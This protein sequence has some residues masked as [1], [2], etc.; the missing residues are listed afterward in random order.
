VPNEGR[1]GQ[2]VATRRLA[3]SHDLFTQEALAFIE[4]H[5]NRPFF[6]YLAYTIPH[7]NNEAGSHGMEVPDLGAY[8]RTDWPEQ[9]KAFAAMVTRLDR[10]VGRLRAKL[11]E[12]DLDR[13]TVLFFSSDNGP[14]REGGHDPNFFQ[15]SGGLRGIKRDLYEGGI[16]VPLIVCWPGHVPAGVVCP[17]LGWFADFL[18]TAAELAGAPVSHPVDGISL[19]PTLL[20]QPGQKERAAP[21]YWEFYEGTTAQALRLGNYKAVC[22]PMWGA[23]E[24]YDLSGDSAEKHDIAQEHPQL[25]QRLRDLMRQAHEPSPLDWRPRRAVPARR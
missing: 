10:D 22:R 21:L 11:Q 23:I 25:V 8:A 4:R 12:L 15:S 14:H 20:G 3:Y 1:W 9:E 24:L 16:R 18:P 6:L 19:V 5:R 17:T 2:G 13:R 7:A